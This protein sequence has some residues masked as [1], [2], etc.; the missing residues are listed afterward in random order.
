MLDTSNAIR[1]VYLS[2]L[3]GN[4]SIDGRNVVVY[5][6]MPF[7]TPG[8]QYVIISSITETPIEENNHKFI[9]QVDVN[10]DIFV[11]QYRFYDNSKVDD[12]SNQILNIL[13]PTNTM[14]DIG[15]ANFE[16]YV[17]RRS[18]SRYLPLESGQN[19]V[20]RKIITLRNFVK[21]K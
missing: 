9:T 17:I 1:S 12:I 15:D 13:I 18:A 11:E 2:K 14:T 8:E 6:Q 4:L 10:I 16:I 7:D 21:Q 20:A 5:G 3:N 19:F